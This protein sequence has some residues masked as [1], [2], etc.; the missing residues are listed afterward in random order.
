[1]DNRD[2]RFKSICKEIETLKKSIKN[3]R[4]DQRQEKSESVKKAFI[5][6][7]SELNS[8]LAWLLLDA[9]EFER[10]LSIYHSLSWRTHGE[11]KYHGISRALI[12]MEYYDDARKVLERGLRRFPE[13]YP[14]L[15]AMGLLHKRLGH[16][17]EALKYF[18][19]ALQIAPD[20]RHALY[21][22]AL[23]L[24]GL[25]HYEEAAPILSNLIEQYPDD[26]EYLVE[27]GYCNLSMGH[28]EDAIPFYMKA[29]DMGFLSP[30]IYGGLCCAYMDMGMKTDAL[31]IATEGLRALPDGHPGLY[32]NLGEVYREMGW[33]DE[34]KGIL[35]E[36][37][38]KF[39]DDE[40][41]K[42]V[43]KEIEDEDDNPDDGK[44]PPI[45][46]LLLLSLLIK[47]FLK[48]KK[49]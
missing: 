22:Q 33:I 46:G 48:Q 24:N 6:Y 11:E 21:D 44:K 8:Q 15:V 30:G 37:L 27:M 45:L 41:I 9:G 19:H 23:S 35:N 25:G 40:G 13:S 39:P 49:G 26:P 12:E 7:I 34:A 32:E 36:G 38:N 14:L 31:E 47:K 4:K 20:N 3:A 43:L 18:E 28:P 1:M 42:K 16:E 29:K 17:F 5:H 10:G 2:P